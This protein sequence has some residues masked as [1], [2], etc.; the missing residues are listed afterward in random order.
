ME[1]KLKSLPQRFWAMEWIVSVVYQIEMR[2][3]GEFS[4]RTGVQAMILMDTY[5]QAKQLHA[6]WEPTVIIEEEAVEVLD[7]TD[8]SIAAI[9]PKSPEPTNTLREGPATRSK[10]TKLEGTVT[11][12]DQTNASATTPFTSMTATSS[13]STQTKP[14]FYTHTTTH[15]VNGYLQT[16]YLMIAMACLHLASK[17]EDVTVISL[18]KLFEYSHSLQTSVI[19][20]VS[21]RKRIV[22]M[23]VQPIDVIDTSERNEDVKFLHRS[24]RFVYD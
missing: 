6:Y 18:T 19:D 20:E 11:T 21:E 4:Q 5:C 22:T 10:R 15:Q 9:T 1:K 24:D 12:P 14:L 7:T 13:I 8:M 16:E 3:D 23:K 2:L 17:M